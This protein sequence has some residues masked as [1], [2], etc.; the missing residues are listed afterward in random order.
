MDAFNH[1]IYAEGLSANDVNNSTFAVALSVQGPA[2]LDGDYNNDGMV[3][4]A[5]YTIYRD[6]L[7]SDS[8]VLNG[9][10]SGAA[11]VVQA[12]YDLW[13]QNFGSSGT[14][15]SAGVP[16]PSAICLLILGASCVLGRVGRNVGNRAA[17][18]LRPGHRHEFRHSGFSVS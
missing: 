4:A 9:N 10:G 14:G 17:R 11:T 3:D 18:R 5:D 8:A 7:G 1:I 12:D 6:N 2:G 16:E 13:K 15:S